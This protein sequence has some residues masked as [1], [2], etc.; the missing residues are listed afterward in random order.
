[1]KRTTI[2]AATL[3]ALAVLTAGAGAATRFLI[4][5][6]GQ[7]KPSVRAQLRGHQGPQGP[8]GPQGAQG[9]PGAPGAVLGKVA[10]AANADHATNADHLGG[11]PAS[12]F[13]TTDNRI[14]T[15]GIVKAAGTAGGNTVTLFTVGPFT[16]TMTCTK[17]GSGT[18]L[19]NNASSSEPN[20][21]LDGTLVPT[22]GTT[23][24][25]GHIATTT[26]PAENNDVNDDFEAPSG[27]EAILVVAEG[28][29]SLGTDCWANWIGLH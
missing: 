23:S 24:D 11:Q 8:R 21:E 14:G 22:A 19:M 13:L 27:A 4:T 29:N 28:V 17:T 25:V 15:N 16:I 20:S 5:N 9:V 3:V 2:V 26:E 1:M 10:N 12:N 7:I 18:S 6:V